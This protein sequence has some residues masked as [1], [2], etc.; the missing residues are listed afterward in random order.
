[1]S[2]LGQLISTTFSSAVS[3]PTYDPYYANVSLLLHADGTNGSTS[4]PDNSPTPKTVT[5][6]GS[7]QVNTSV[8]K[9]G[10]GSLAVDNSGDYLSTLAN[11]AFDFGGGI[12]FT[13]EGWFNPLIEP[14]YFASLFSQRLPGGFCP[15]EVRQA[16]AGLNWLIQEA[17]AGSW[18][19]NATTIQGIFTT[20]NW[21]FVAIVGDGTN[22]VLYV[23]GISRLT[24]S[25][26][27]WISENRPMYIGGGGDANFIGKVD[28]FR[29]T[30]GVARYTSNFTPPTQPFPNQ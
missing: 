17:P 13:V 14:A 4:F 19:V 26:P 10:T 21:N 3:P 2:V 25:Q 24:A 18:I 7:A 29:V 12:A 20:N 1:M 9:Y 22:L 28:D 30:K 27:S 8:V 5:A 23:N 16:G 11:S 6:N 15:F